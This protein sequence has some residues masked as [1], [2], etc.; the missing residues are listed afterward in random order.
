MN[1]NGV[2]YNIDD[3]AN[4][5]R[6]HGQHRPPCSLQ[7]TLSQNLDKNTG[8]KQAADLGI[9]NAALYRLGHL[10]LHGK[11]G[12]GSEN[13]EQHEQGRGNDDKKNTVSRRPIRRVLVLLSQTFGQQA[14]HAHAD[15]HAKAN[16]HI[17][18]RKCQR[19]GRY[20]ALGNLRNIDTVHNVIK[21]LNQHGNDHGQRHVHQ[22]LRHG[23]DAHLVFLQCIRLCLHGTNLL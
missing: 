18:H 17:L 5:L 20:C 8:R 16:L 6:D 12:S 7:Q 1:E 4:A 3:G 14:V 15:T 10:G 13:A 19:Q 11:I 22:Q 2:Q 9:G 21:R 23:H